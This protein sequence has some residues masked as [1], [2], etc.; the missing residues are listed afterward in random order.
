MT[1]PPT[2]HLSLRHG[3]FVLEPLS[4]TPARRVKPSTM[5]L[6]SNYASSSD[7]DDDDTGGVP[8]AAPAPAPV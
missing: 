1:R 4:P 3:M 7:D 5:A 8:V 2:G 6:V